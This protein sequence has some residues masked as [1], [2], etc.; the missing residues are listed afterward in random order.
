VKKNDIII[1]VVV[2]LAVIAL[3]FL[4][5][6]IRG[7]GNKYNW[8]ENYRIDSEEP[9]GNKVITALLDGYFPTK[10]F[11]SASSNINEF[12]TAETAEHQVY[13]FIGQ[14][15]YYTDSTFELLKQF[16]NKGN[17]VFIAT[18]SIPENISNGI[19]L[20]NEAPLATYDTVF[21]IDEFGDSSYALIDNYAADPSVVSSFKY[22]KMGMNFLSPGF[23]TAKGFQFAPLNGTKPLF[24]D[25]N[26]FYPEYLKRMSAYTP[27]GT[28]YSRNFYNYIQVPFGE[29]NFYIHLNPIVFT[30]FFQIEA[31]NINY[32][33]KV[34]SYLKPGNII[35]DDFSKSYN[36]DSNTNNDAQEEGP[37]KFIL[38]NISL[39]YAWYTIL[40]GLML[41][42][43]FRTKRIQQPIAIIEP[44]ENKSL[45]FVQTIGRMYFLKKN[46]KQ[47]AHQK[48][49]LLLHYIND[50]YRI[51]TQ[52]ID[53]EFYTKVKLKS[54]MREDDIRKIFKHYKYIENTNEVTNEDL[55]E[56]HS[57][58]D[59]FYKNCK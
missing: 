6:S 13:I 16:A 53:D 10:D 52:H 41:F 30:N 47:L 50:K 7:K 36:R 5:I 32:T 15:P 37:L 44:N 46:H 58:I 17:D 54:E 12:L 29:G 9:Y 35:Y 28:I 20:H 39:R 4:L 55:I 38:S 48:I 27:I 59:Y 14:Y 31:E 18:N 43:V 45:E 51:P 56:L 1:V 57:L 49:K 21:Y 19:L 40:A 8:S 26:Y 33:S 23:R 24:N 2:L 3:V 42:L 22:T 34:F 25:W 11:T